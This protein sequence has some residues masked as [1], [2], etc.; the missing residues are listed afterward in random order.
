[1]YKVI[2]TQSTASYFAVNYSA[3]FLE[4]APTTSDYFLI[5]VMPSASMQE[6]SIFFKASKYLETTLRTNTEPVSIVY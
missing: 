3:R 1:M 6:I 5:A 4:V 2:D